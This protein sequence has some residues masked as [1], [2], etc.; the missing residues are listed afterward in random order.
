M[1]GDVCS[2]QNPRRKT[3]WVGFCRPP[4][5]SLLRPIKKVVSLSLTVGKR[6]LVNNCQKEVYLF[7]YFAFEV[8]RP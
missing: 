1:F 8:S 5:I 6:T 2:E 3:L 4:L 7:I